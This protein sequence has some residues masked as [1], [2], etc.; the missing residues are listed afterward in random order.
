MVNSGTEATMSAIRLARGATNQ[1]LLEICGNYHGH[2]DAL[3]VATGSG[4]LTMG[5]PSSAGIPDDVTKNTRV[6]N[7]ADALIQ[8]FKQEGA[9]IGHYYGARMRQYG[10]SAT[11][12]SIFRRLCI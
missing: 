6:L 10:G 3:L 1:T 12:S 4:G 7:N 9:N 2:V 11:K 8:L 5:T